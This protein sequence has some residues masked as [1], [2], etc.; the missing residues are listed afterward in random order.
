[1]TILDGRAEGGWVKIQFERVIIFVMKVR[2]VI[3]AIILA[4][5]IVSGLTAAAWFSRPNVVGL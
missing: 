4:L 5:A 1:M 2:F 3:I